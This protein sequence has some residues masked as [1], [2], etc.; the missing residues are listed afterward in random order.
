MPAK[1]TI[2]TKTATDGVGETGQ[3][4]LLFLHNISI[5]GLFTSYDEF[6]H[7]NKP[8]KYS[9]FKFIDDSFKYDGRDYNRWKKSNSNNK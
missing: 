4:V 2:L 3:Y 5:S 7:T 9:I 1:R 6:L 8:G